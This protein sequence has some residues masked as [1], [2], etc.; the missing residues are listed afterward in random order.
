QGVAGKLPPAWFVPALPNEADQ[1]AQ[2]RRR[3]CMTG[4]SCAVVLIPENAPAQD[5][6]LMQSFSAAAYRGKT[7]RLRAWLRLEVV[8][9]GDRAEMWLGIKRVND[10]KGF[11]D[12]MSDRPLR[13]EEW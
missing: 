6:N 8:D 12:D 9:A 13:R 1:W 3:G 4:S 2:L 10:Q 5:G 11:F 7:V